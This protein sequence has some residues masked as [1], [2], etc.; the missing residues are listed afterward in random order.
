MILVIDSSVSKQCVFDD[1]QNT[2]TLS[3]EQELDLLYGEIG[4]FIIIPSEQD[5]SFNVTYSLPPNYKSQAP[6]IFEIRED[7]T[8]DIINYEIL[9]DTDPLNIVIKFNIAPSE[10]EDPP[11]VHFDFWVLVENDEFDDLPSD[12]EIPAERDLSDCNDIW[13]ESTKA[14]Q[15]DSLLIKLKAWLL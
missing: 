5:D 11:F 2:K 7:T 14:V 1:N 9:N 12:V 13:L 4:F 15:S 3:C 10:Y 8:A 6:I